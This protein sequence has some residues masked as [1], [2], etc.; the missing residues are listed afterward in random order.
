MNKKRWFYLILLITMFMAFFI[1]PF[2]A[3]FSNY[4][5]SDKPFFLILNNNSEIIKAIQN[6]TG[7]SLYKSYTKIFGNTNLSE[8]MFNFII[9]FIN[10][11][12][13]FIAVNFY[14][15]FF[16]QGSVLIINDKKNVIKNGIIIY[17]LSIALIMLFF[18]SVVGFG[19]SFVLILMISVVIFLGKIS[20]SIMIGYYITKKIIEHNNIYF[21]MITGY[22]LIELLQCLPYIGW[23]VSGISIPVITIGIVAQTIINLYVNKKFYEIPYLE[24]KVNN[25]FDKEKMYDIIISNDKKNDYSD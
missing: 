6:F 18:A 9:S 25:S 24:V 2:A 13:G 21:N 16:Q 19:I 10:F 7:F 4:D 17:G 14:K 15:A 11:G 20:L 23:L 12:T 5:I 8:L 22:V 1:K 3:L